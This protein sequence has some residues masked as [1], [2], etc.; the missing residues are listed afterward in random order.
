MVANEKVDSR[1]NVMRMY[2]P[3]RNALHRNIERR[4][5]MFQAFWIRTKVY[6][7]M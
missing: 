4:I 6:I 7:S 1:A 2:S 5:L 3:L